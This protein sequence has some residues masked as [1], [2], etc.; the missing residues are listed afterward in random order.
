MTTALRGTF[1]ISWS[2]TE[3]D[4]FKGGPLHSLAV[5][6]TWS[7]SGDTLC[8]DGPTD[9]LRLEDAD[10]KEELRLCAARRVRQLIGM[11]VTPPELK[12]LQ[13]GMHPLTDS[14]FVV[15][16]GAQS[17]T[18]TVVSAGPGR[19]PL[20]MFLDDIPP[21]NTDLWVVH[22]ALD[23]TARDAMNA[24]DG[25]V[26]CFTLGTMIQTPDG[27][28]RIDELR[29]GDMVQT[30]DNGPQEILWRGSRRMSGARLFV[31]PRLRPIR[32]NASAFG[33]DLPDSSFLVSPDHK[34]VVRGA[35][36]K[37]LFN[38]DEVLVSAKHLINHSSISVD[39][40]VRS[41]TYVHLLLPRHEVLWANGVETE[42]FHPANTSLA[43]LADDDR[44]R[45]LKELPTLETDPHV[46]GAYARRTLND[47]EAALL[48]HAA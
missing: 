43:T 6:S 28:K 44:G 27:P 11:A 31:M 37:D 45:L 23:T 4:G 24:N 26:I 21:A 48:N 15:T 34:M 32:I 20:A 16:D 30:K 18:V 19:W 12:H 1:V 33:E 8:V 41:V 14:S 35:I 29:E 2:Q 3:V 47:S 9:V 10:G 17:Y 5:G 7:W 36:A 39:L 13:E 40:D 42:S 25:G 38:T 46:Y 22:H